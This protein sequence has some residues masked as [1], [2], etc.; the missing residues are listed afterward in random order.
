M[1][2]FSQLVGV[3]NLSYA[4]E[5]VTK[6]RIF[7][8][9]V[10]ASNHYGVPT[11]SLASRLKK[12]YTPEE[13]VKEIRRGF[14]KFDP[15]RPGYIYKITNNQ[16][17]KVYI[18]LTVAPIENRFK[19]HRSAARKGRID[20]P[21]Y[22]AMVEFGLQN[23]S[24]RKIKELPVKELQEAEK[25]Y[26]KKYKSQDP[27]HGYNVSPGGTLG[28]NPGQEVRYKGKLYA[29]ISVFCR[30]FSLSTDQYTQILQYMRGHGMSLAEA[31]D[32][33]KLSWKEKRSKHAGTKIKVGGQT[34]PS[35][36]EACVQLAI[37]YDRALYRI[38]NGLPLKDALK[39]DKI[40]PT[41]VPIRYKGRSYPTMSQAAEDLG[42]HPSRI[43]QRISKFGMS[44]SE[45]VRD[46]LR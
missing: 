10:E 9:M 44:F 6:H 25:Y 16:N 1:R 39:P 24:V 38:N 31:Y 46:I 40:S 2:S 20:L 32:H 35:L 28:N 26:I 3:V 7:P 11:R 4:K 12:G 22:E 41:A 19:Q 45:A 13:A 21:L 14:K 18:G 42:I 36:K 43:Y 17:N 34:Y 30:K 5:V 8:S 29:S 23:F 15:D 27:E 37:N 33:S